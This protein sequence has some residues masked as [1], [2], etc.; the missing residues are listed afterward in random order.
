[1]KYKYVGGGAYLHGL[2]AQDLDDTKLDEDQKAL[3]ERGVAYGLYE[4]VEEPV[5]AKKAPPEKAVGNE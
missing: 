2:P 3:L 4:P 5:K 1:M